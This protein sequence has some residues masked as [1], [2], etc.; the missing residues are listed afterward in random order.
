MG[1]I[2]PLR[3]AHLNSVYAFLA[4]SPVENVMLLGQLL[5]EGLPELSGRAFV[6]YH[7]QGRW[8]GVAY[9]AG[10]ISIYAPHEAA[11]AP[12]AR[13]ALARRPFVP[14]VIGRRETIDCFWQ[15]FGQAPYPVLFDRQQWVY[16]LEPGELTEPSSAPLRP[17]RL[18]EAR[19]VAELA[20]AMSLEEIMQDPLHEQPL[21]YMRLIEQRI[22]RER[23]YILK[24]DGVIKFQVHLN[25]VTPECGQI[26]GVYTP[27]AH[28]RAGH[29]R[30]GLAAF[31]RAAFHRVPR[32]SLFVNDFNAPAIHLYEAL[33]FR[34]V[35]PY[36]AIFLEAEDY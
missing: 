25:A 19:E 33:G 30:R 26:T 17:A 15:E 10:D 12:L 3:R 2:V 1:E 27:P 28:R 11:I 23:Y 24:E 20:S 21:M 16:A 8:L 7:E 36:R 6:G 31:C 34:R 5:D 35:M 32:L 14:R 9:F 13:Y 18:D 4:E 22:R 29:A